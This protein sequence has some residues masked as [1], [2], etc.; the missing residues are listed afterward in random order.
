MTTNGLSLE[1]AHAALR[2]TGY[3]HMC[4]YL[5]LIDGDIYMCTPVWGETHDD[6]VHTV[7]AV[8][9]AHQA[10]GHHATME[11]GQT[12][13]VVFCEDCGIPTEEEKASWA[14]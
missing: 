7:K 6:V 13:A 4:K 14:G 1:V 10:A 12:W 2:E 9:L 11:V 3:E 5:R 8:M